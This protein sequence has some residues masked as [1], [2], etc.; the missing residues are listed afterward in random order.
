MIQAIGISKSYP[1]AKRRALDGVSLEAM[2]GEILGIIGPNGSGKT[3]LMGCLL[4]LLKPDEGHA[5]L[6]G[7]EPSSL[8]AKAMIGYLPERLRF[9]SW[10]TGRSFM[11]FHYD[12]ARRPAAARSAVVEACLASC[13]LDPMAWER[14]I[15]GYSRGMLQRIGLAQS[16]IGAP[17]CLFLDEPTSGMD[18]DGAILTRKLLQDFAAEG[19]TVLINSHQLEQVSKICHRVAFLREGRLEELRVL[20]GEAATL[21]YRVRWIKEPEGGP[22]RSELAEILEKGR[23]PAEI[24]QR[25]RSPL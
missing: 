22:K 18:P 21:K 2:P 14:P 13:G 9:D 7:H 1:R 5:L 6:G 25:Q 23:G 12:L 15:K 4:G 20:Q 16:L 24:A 3:S 19:G 10:M 11:G 17:K 8:Q